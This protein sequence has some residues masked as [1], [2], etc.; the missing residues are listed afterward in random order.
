[1][2]V[3]AL[4]RIPVDLMPRAD[5]PRI[6][7]TTRYDGVAPQEIETLITRPV[8]QALS[9][10]AGVEEIEATSSEG[11][12]RVSLEFEWGTDLDVAAADIRAQLDRL[13]NRLPEDAER[14][15]VFKFDLSS[16]P[17]A[18]LGVAG[19]GDPRSLRYLAEETL[20]RRI[21]RLPGAASVSVRGGRVREIQVR[22]HGDRLAALGL[23]AETV[24]QALRAEN[25]NVSGGD[26]LD[27][28]RALVVRTL[29]EL[30]EADQIERVVVASRDGRPIHVA[31]VP[32][33]AA[34][35]QELRSGR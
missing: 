33:V 6:N 19:G 10:I 21:E 2:G 23:S 20:A 12:S 34:A 24:I 16:F 18:Q 9:S 11:L 25:R 28:G 31:D 32:D 3:V 8:E 14:P 5:M 27:D 17:V 29:G 7:V 22:L 4:G 26:L 1:L 15:L 13:V 30:E 35:H